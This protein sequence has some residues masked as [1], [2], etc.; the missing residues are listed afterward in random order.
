[1][2]ASQGCYNKVW[3]TE[4]LETIQIYS[5]TVLESEIKVSSGPALSPNFWFLPELFGGVS[6][7]CLTSVSAS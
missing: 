6:Y 2:C 7:S 3:Q 4:W 1:M 5:L